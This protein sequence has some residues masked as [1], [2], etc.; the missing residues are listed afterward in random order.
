M[1]WTR[2]AE[3]GTTRETRAHAKLLSRDKRHEAA[4]E[5]YKDDPGAHVIDFA[6]P[7]SNCQICGT[8][9]GMRKPGQRYQT[10]AHLSCACCRINVCGPGCWKLL[11]GYYKMG[12]EPEEKA[13]E[14]RKGSQQAEEAAE[15]EECESDADDEDDEM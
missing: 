5:S 15:C 9:R 3:R 8:G 7:K 2:L 10:G 12:E 6:K 11:H 13:G 1:D 14:F 4:I